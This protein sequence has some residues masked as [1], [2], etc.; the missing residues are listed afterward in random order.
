MTPSCPTRRVDAVLFDMDDTL[1]ATAESYKAAWT[2]APDQLTAHHLDLATLLA[3][4]D[5]ARPGLCGADAVAATCAALGAGAETKAMLAQVVDDFLPTTLPPHAGA[6]ALLSQLRA[7]GIATGLVTNGALERQNAKVVALGLG[8]LLDVVVVAGIATMAAKPDPAP[9][10]AALQALGVSAP[11]TLF[12]GDHPGVDIAPAVALGMHTARLA[13][14]HHAS[15]A[16]APGCEL[17]TAE[18]SAVW[19]YV[20][21]LAGI[22]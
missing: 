6:L 19:D 13:S 20:R 17:D 1:Y 12:V 2:A 4:Y 18:P 5:L 21:A 16:P 22:S 11:V 3:A 9:F 8:G 15:H 10:L 7:A 14:G